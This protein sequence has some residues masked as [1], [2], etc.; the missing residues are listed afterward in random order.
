MRYV[1]ALLLV[2]GLLGACGAPEVIS[3]VVRE[4]V[5]TPT[6][7]LIPSSSPSPTPTA[8]PTTTPTPT[9]TPMP[10]PPSVTDAVNHAKRYV[11]RINH[12]GGC[13][14]GVLLGTQRLIL[15]NFHAID[16]AQGLVAITDDGTISPLKLLRS[17]P[18]RDP[19]FTIPE[20]DPLIWQDDTTLETGTALL[21]IGYP[22]C[23]FSTPTVNTTS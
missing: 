21:L 8:T 19:A 17:D 14:S 3:R 18:Q 5:A 10:T 9:A 22:L 1:L 20:P 2:A 6:P 23:I 12:S 16:G 15:T 13:A 4:I 7:T 11:V